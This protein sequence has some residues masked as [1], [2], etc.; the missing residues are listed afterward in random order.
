MRMPPMNHQL[1][2]SHDRIKAASPGRVDSFNKRSPTLFASPIP[3]FIICKE[4]TEHSC[5]FSGF[6]LSILTGA[7]HRKTSKYLIPYSHA[8]VYSTM[9]TSHV[10]VQLLFND[11][12]QT[13]SLS[14][15]AGT[16]ITCF[17]VITLLYYTT[18]KQMIYKHGFRQ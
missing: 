13:S 6:W 14:A 9:L 7:I 5:I 4:T 2:A 8:F 1:L 11:S 3:F 16:L 18:M 17:Q 12:M 15:C 10:P